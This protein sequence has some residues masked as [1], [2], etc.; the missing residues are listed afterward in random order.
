MCAVVLFCV[1]TSTWGVSCVELPFFL[2]CFAASIPCAQT[3]ETSPCGP[4][5]ILN[6]CHLFVKVNDVYVRFIAGVSSAI[7][8]I[9]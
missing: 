6:F 8:C 1:S 5:A 7:R 4:W 9:S 2:L 3:V